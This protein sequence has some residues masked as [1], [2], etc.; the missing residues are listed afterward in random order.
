MWRLK[1]RAI[2]LQCGDENT[3][4]FQ[5]FAKGRKFSNSIWELSSA[6]GEP[7]SSFDGMADMG[8]KYFGDL[9]SA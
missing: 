4:K 9:F 8:V 1:S 5:A 3:K 7:V 2:W 6:E